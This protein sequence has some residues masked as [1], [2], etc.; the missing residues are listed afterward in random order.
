MSVSPK[1]TGS[2]AEAIFHIETHELTRGPRAQF[3]N[4]STVR[5]QKTPQGIFFKAAGPGNGG[6]LKAALYQ[7]TTLYKADYFGAKLFNTG[8]GTASG[9]EV[10][11]AKCLAGR[12]LAYETTDSTLLLYDYG[13]TA[14]CG[15]NLRKA[16]GASSDE[17]QVIHPRYYKADQS[18]I[19][20]SQ[21]LVLVAKISSGTNIFDDTGAEIK[22]L[23]ISPQRFWAYQNGQSG[24]FPH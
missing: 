10:K 2:D 20:V 12:M 8:S 18:G 22:Y 23:E 17:W 24:L 9:S 13:A 21:S 14:D 4:S 3:R 19:N 7:I 16:S 15:D 6:S 11:V 1:P 5:V